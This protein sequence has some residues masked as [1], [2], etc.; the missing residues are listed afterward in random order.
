MGMPRFHFKGQKMKTANKC[1]KVKLFEVRDSMTRIHVMAVRFHIL[2]SC[3]LSGQ[4]EWNLRSA[5]WGI[6][7]HPIYVLK[8]QGERVGAHCEP[9]GW[10]D[11]TMTAAHEHI[12]SK[13]DELESGD[14]LDVRFIIGE[15]D[16]PCSSDRFYS[17]SIGGEQ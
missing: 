10:Q 2:G 14:V 8:L 13:W 12:Q 7:Q 16:A 17:Q 1:C 3:L 4:D 15:T 5:G 9:Y 6:D 11:R